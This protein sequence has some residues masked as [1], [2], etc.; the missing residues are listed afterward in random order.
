MLKYATQN[1]YKNLLTDQALSQNWRKKAIR[2][3]GEDCNRINAFRHFES[4]YRR[5]VAVELRH[6][7]PNCTLDT[8]AAGGT[9]STRQA[10]RDP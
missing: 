7:V 4:K 1:A 5:R 2:Y 9:Q 10:H 3:L 6:E 8:A